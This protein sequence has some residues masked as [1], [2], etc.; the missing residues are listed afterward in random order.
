MAGPDHPLRRRA[1]ETPVLPGCYLFRSAVGEALYVGKARSL[2]ARVR[3]YFRAKA[4][5]PP[6]I[7]RMLEEA[8]ELEFIVTGS[9]VEALI[10]ENNLIKKEKPRFNVLLRDDKNFPYLKLTV[11]DP[12]PRLVLVRRA[13][14]DSSQYFGPYLPASH[15]RRTLRMAARYFKVAPCYEK[16]DGSRGRPCL[17]YHLD[18]CLGPCTEGLTTQEE[19]S[20]AVEHLRLFLKGKNQALLG[21]LRALMQEAS[22]QQEFERAAHYRDLI[23]DVEKHSRK[24]NFARVGLE[25]QDYFHYHREGERAVVQVFLMRGGQ[26]E[27]RREFSFEQL[28]GEEE[29]QFLAFAV[30]QYYASA[31][32]VPREVHVPQQVADTQLLE[33]W[34]SGLRGESVRV[35]VPRRGVK[36]QFM[37]TVHRNA[38]LAFRSRFQEGHGR[39]VEA[40]A[41]LRDA[42]DLDEAP[43]RIEAFDI[44]HLQGTAVVASMV[45]WEGGRAHRAAY[46]HFKVKTVEGQDDYASM[47]E[48]VG[49]R[50]TRLVREERRMP[51]LILIDGGKGQLSAAHQA[52]KESGA[53]P[54]PMAA[55]AKR[56]EEIFLPGRSQAIRLQR[57]SP[58]LQLLQQVRD[59]A[60][61]FALTYHRKV[62]SRARLVSE[63]ESIPGV[64]RA[65]SSKLLRG[66]GSLKAVQAAGVDELA[67]LVPRAVARAIQEHFRLAAQAGPGRSS[68]SPECP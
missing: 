36:A 20:G 68:P 67:G 46:R 24:Q 13:R 37:E 47:A 62:R 44:S 4:A 56:E 43:Y 40:L 3:S 57:S 9:E 33:S 16:L 61:R 6:R 29:E 18:Q 11:A 22:C 19:Y 8:V 26:V 53:P 10:L 64:G 52:L 38:Q 63:L 14:E 32:H 55:L 23:R 54:V 30:Q 15:A 50:Y 2:K 17:Y 45:V 21:R 25:D 65:R 59:E 5:H 35:R 12:Y 51:D 39:G 7:L 34:L 60:H 42:L 28:S 66:L 27:A 58:A 1:E 48:V 31:E 41:Q 49:R